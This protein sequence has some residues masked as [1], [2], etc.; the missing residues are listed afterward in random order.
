MREAWLRAFR[1]PLRVPFAL[2]GQRISARCG[3]ILHLR[4]AGCDGLGEAAPLPGLSAESFDEAAAVLA[5]AARAW[6]EGATVSVPEPASAAWAW[7]AAQHELQAGPLE[8]HAPSHTAVLLGAPLATLEAE[9]DQAR[10]TA[11]AA[12]LAKVKVGRGALAEDIERLRLI[13]RCWPAL[14]LRLDG[15]RSWTLADVL[16]L[17]HALPDLPVAYLEEPLEDPGEL[18]QMFHQCGWAY[19][20]DESLHAPDFVLKGEPGLAALVLKPTLYGALDRC[21]ALVRQARAMGIDTVLSSCFESL[22]GNRQLQALAAC[23][24]P[25]VVPGLDTLKYLGHPGW[26]RQALCGGME[27]T[28]ALT[29]CGYWQGPNDD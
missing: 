4:E 10:R 5:A 15:N 28:M 7:S 19:A 6:C 2:A 20:L 21:Q 16:A 25:G 17:K 13:A 27:D 12:L 24:S 26:R 23:W 9:I 8:P 1:L 3:L 22:L 18:A 29:C 11:P 14:R